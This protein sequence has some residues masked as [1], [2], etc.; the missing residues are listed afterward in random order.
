M[1]IRHIC[2]SVRGLLHKTNAELN[3][4]AK[5]MIVDG[6]KLT[7]AYEVREALM[8]ELSQGHEVLPTCECDNFDYKTGCKGHENNSQ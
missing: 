2:V 6:K 3:R 7:T 1:A 4:M 8:D 5:Y